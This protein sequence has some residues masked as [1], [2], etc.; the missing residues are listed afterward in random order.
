[1]DPAVGRILDANFNRA[2]E[3]L[4]V[5]EDFARFVLDSAAL[6][7]RAK[8]I[9]HALR[10]SY[11]ATGGDA[12]HLS[13]RDTPGD[14]GT[15]VK[16]ADE[17]RREDAR[18]VLSANLKRLTEALRTL[19]EYAKTVSP[20]AA[21]GF[22]SARYAVYSL[23]RDLAAWLTPSRRFASVRLYVLI[24]E[25]LCSGPL[26]QV[27]EAV[28]A[29]GADCL[30]LREKTATDRR[31][32]ELAR[33]LRDLTAGRC[34]L[35]INDRPDIAALSHADG[36]HVGQ[37]EIP[38][39]DARRVVGADRIVGV[40]T[41]RIEQAR[42][43]VADG[44]DYIG[45]GPVFRSPTKPRDFVAGTEYLRQ[46]AAEIPIPH[47]AIAGITPDNLGEVLAAG[48]RCVAVCGAVISQPDPGAAA[49]EF[50]RRLSADH[51]RG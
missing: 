34:L 27:A 46:V 37:E 17:G 7:E 1:M 40:S 9:R 33:Q 12:A 47:A 26:M 44:A 18:A 19:E 32:L 20:A 21:A 35:I 2:R 49:A 14:V 24:T 11:E 8:T 15:A 22:E 36:V 25:S 5:V 38:A 51:P 39:P 43:A 4:R 45:V 13:A 6:T 10:T 30:Q 23:E 29:G 16:A 41:H 48:G 28:V 42:R 3:G 50:K 31:F